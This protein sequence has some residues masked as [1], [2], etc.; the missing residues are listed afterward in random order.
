MGSFRIFHLS[1]YHCHRSDA[2]TVFIDCSTLVACINHL[3]KRELAVGFEDIKEVIC[4]TFDRNNVHFRIRRNKIRIAQK[5]IK[6]RLDV[7]YRGAV[8]FYVVLLLIDSDVIMC[9]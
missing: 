6:D 8:P 3:G 7:L 5:F 1:L 9:D 2:C 4:T